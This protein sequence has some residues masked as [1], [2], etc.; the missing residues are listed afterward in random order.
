[1]EG[2]VSVLR[3]DDL[4]PILEPETGV[5]GNVRR[6]MHPWGRQAFP[7]ESQEYQF[8]CAMASGPDNVGTK[9]NEK[10]NFLTAYSPL[11]SP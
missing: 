6:E 7:A 3:P 2:S 1:M 10:L 11:T 4:S 8:P 5:G 9:A